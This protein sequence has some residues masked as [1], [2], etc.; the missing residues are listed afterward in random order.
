MSEKKRKSHAVDEGRPA[1]K[2]ATDPNPT[3]TVTYIAGSDI[4][5]PVIGEHLYPRSQ[6]LLKYLSFHTGCEF[7]QNAQL[8][9]VCEA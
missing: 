9:V 6:T 2:Q 5:R 1:K 4:T 3:L 7:A 8:P